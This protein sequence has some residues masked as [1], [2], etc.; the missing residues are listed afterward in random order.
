M[1]CQS[2]QSRNICWIALA[3]CSTVYSGWV[4]NEERKRHAQKE[5]MRAEQINWLI[6]CGWELAGWTVFAIFV[7]SICILAEFFTVDLSSPK[8]NIPL[9]YLRIRNWKQ[10]FGVFTVLAIGS[11]IHVGNQF[12]STRRLFLQ[13]SE[14]W[15]YHMTQAQS[16]HRRKRKQT[17]SCAAHR[18]MFS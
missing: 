15:W 8:N 16:A 18:L 11:P 10:N 4:Q 14:S 7:Y 3:C 2:P 6:K 1:E 17:I 9:R 12:F 13:V 5:L